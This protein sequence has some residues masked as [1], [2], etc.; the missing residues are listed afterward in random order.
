MSKER[1][2]VHITLGTELIDGIDAYIERHGLLSRN[3]AIRRFIIKGLSE[4]SENPFDTLKYII[5]KK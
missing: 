2:S 1:R 3:E 5:K 4:K